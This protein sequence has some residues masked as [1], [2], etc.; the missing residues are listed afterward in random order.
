MWK[1]SDS[2]GIEH[3]QA[4]KKNEKF[5]KLHCKQPEREMDWHDAWHHI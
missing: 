5:M 4:P 2:R 3:W 1:N